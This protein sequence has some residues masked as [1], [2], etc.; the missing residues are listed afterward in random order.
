MRRVYI[1][2]HAEREFGGWHSLLRKAHVHVNHAVIL[3]K[4]YA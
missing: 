4:G 1:N 3:L 2:A